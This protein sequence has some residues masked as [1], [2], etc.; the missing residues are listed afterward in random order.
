MIA[1]AMGRRSARER[2]GTVEEPVEVNSEFGA[3]RAPNAEE[4]H[5]NDP[6]EGLHSRRK[7]ITGAAMGFGLAAVA[8][9]DASPAA[10]STIS[11]RT[12]GATRGARSVRSK[13]RVD[14]INSGADFVVQGTSS[15]S[16]VVSFARSGVVSIPGGQ[17][18]VTETGV[19][20]SS[21][22]VVLATIQTVIRGLYIEAV[23]PDVATS[24][25][26]IFLSQRVPPGKTVTV[27]W[28][29]VN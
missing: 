11:R 19:S 13:T 3:S 28:F 17:T 18:T 7:L 22:S 26:E 16:D 23:V 5:E 1:A 21:T 2:G 25:F 27:G 15:F 4:W 10:A 6:T 14:A 9:A 20:L 12:T 8:A 29:I 24:S